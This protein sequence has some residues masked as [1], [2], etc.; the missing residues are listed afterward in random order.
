MKKDNT[1]PKKIHYIWFG[2]WPK[3]YKFQKY[4]DSWRKH[5]PDYEIIEWNEDNFDITQNEYCYD[6]Y[7]RKKWAFASDYARFYVLYNHGWIYLDTDVE[8]I[9]NFDKFL[10]NDAFIG[11]QDTLS[12]W[13]AIIWAN[14]WN[15]IIKEILEF[16]ETKKTR[17]I[18]PNLLNKIFKKHWNIKYSWKIKNIKNFT[19]YPKDYFYTYAYY[20]K[21]K[22]M[23]ITPN[24]HTIH[25]YDATWLPKIITNLFFP[26]IW[27]VLKIKNR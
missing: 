3:S 1:I 22:N 8:I 25:H 21:P 13:W 10:D 9:N 5:C 6:F 15:Q 7:K 12:I 16:Y 26:I 2:K 23:I 17:I 24:T 14:K 27:F 19:L 4:L 20:E 11:F 18:L